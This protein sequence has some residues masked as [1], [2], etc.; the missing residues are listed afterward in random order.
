MHVRSVDSAAFLERVQSMSLANERL[1]FFSL[2]HV[3]HDFV[4][5]RKRTNRDEEYLFGRALRQQFTFQRRNRQ[6]DID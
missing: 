6:I 4:D 5:A 3:G 1:L 2:T